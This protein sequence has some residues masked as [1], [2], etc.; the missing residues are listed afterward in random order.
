MASK[1]DVCNIALS[2]LGISKEI[3]NVQ[4]EQSK[5]AQA[6]RRFYDETRKAVLNDYPWPFAT[7]FVELGLIQENPTEEWAYSYRYPV[8]CIYIRRILSGFRDDTEATKIVYKIG[9]DSQGM[10]IYTDQPDAV[11][12]YTKDEESADLFPSDFVLALSYRLAHYIAPRLTAGD[13]FGLGDK[14]NAK[15]ELE[16][17]KASSN[18]FNEDNSS[19]RQDTESIA[20]RE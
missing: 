17:S 10:L 1:T 11:V 3:A 8:D 7:K 12:E 9:Q 2:H 4:T 19:I 20:A 15:Y 14:A 18:K 16:I 5:E 13:P 6:C